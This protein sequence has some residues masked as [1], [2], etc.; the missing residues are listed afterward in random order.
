MGEGPIGFKGGRSGKGERSRFLSK[1]HYEQKD[2]KKLL[3]LSLW[4][5]NDLIRNKEKNGYNQ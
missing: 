4:I 3:C 1:S 5:R 2:N